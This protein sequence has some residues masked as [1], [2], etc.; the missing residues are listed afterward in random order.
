M[1]L[2]TIAL[3]L[4]VAAATAKIFVRMPLF[5]TKSHRDIYREANSPI[6]DYDGT[7]HEYRAHAHSASTPC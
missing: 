3:T 2:F 1:K 6:A 5:K 7:R 4:C